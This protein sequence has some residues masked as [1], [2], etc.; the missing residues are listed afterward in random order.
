ML[1]IR[2]KNLTEYAVRILFVIL[3]GLVAHCALVVVKGGDGRSS[4]D[5]DEPE[6]R[7]SLL[8]IVLA[9]GAVAVFMLPTSSEG[10][11][12]EKDDGQAKTIHENVPP[13]TDVQSESVGPQQPVEPQQLVEPQKPSENPEIAARPD[14]IEQPR[15]AAAAVGADASC[16]KAQEPETE[17]ALP[18]EPGDG[19]A[20]ANEMAERMWRSARKIRHNFIPDLNQDGQYLNL[21][22]GAAMSGH[23]KA[24]AKLGDYAL[25]RGALVEAYYWMKLSQ[26]NGSADA[27]PNLIACRERWMRSACPLEYKNVYQLFTERQSSLG[28]AFL[29]L[30]CGVQAD[31]AMQRIRSMAAEGEAV[32]VMMLGEMPEREDV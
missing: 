2:S 15:S 10:K 4:F 8:V 22:H 13:K 24:Q 3:L 19:E 11:T 20:F 16:V 14:P 29:R 17:S 21:L 32:A 18:A 31:M 5:F 7:R 6:R 26:L 12:A 9:V 28:R 23:P 1:S 25:R 27:E 30:D